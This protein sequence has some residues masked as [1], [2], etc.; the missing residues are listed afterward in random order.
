M[1]YV[2]AN[3]A[4]ALKSHVLEEIPAGEKIRA[5]YLKEP[6]QGRM[7]S[8]LFLFTPE[9][10]VLMGDLVPDGHGSISTYGYGVGWFSNGMS[11][12]YLCSKFI[13]KV[14][15]RECA[16]EWLKEQIAQLERGESDQD[17]DEAERVARAKSFREL[18]EDERALA[19][20]NSFHDALSEIDDYLVD[21]G[22]PGVDYDPKTAGWLCALQQRFA[23]AFAKLPDPAAEAAA[24]RAGGS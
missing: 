2:T 16:V 4:E 11:E 22:A 24:A 23:A 19:D 10:I 18:V 5:F 8:T 20:Y 14:W 21:D 17:L 15:V 7:M 12:N 1:S 3:M 9:G 6:G 13:P